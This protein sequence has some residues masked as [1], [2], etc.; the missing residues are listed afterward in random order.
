MG[1]ITAKLDNGFAYITLE[2]SFNGDDSTNLEMEIQPILNET[3]Y[4]FVELKDVDRD[5]F[6]ALLPAFQSALQIG[7]FFIL[8][9]INDDIKSYL[10]EAGYAS[11]FIIRDSYEEAMKMF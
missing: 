10:E 11:T 6:D 1:E 3:G 8:I 5:S 9:D 7:A 2:G 4:F